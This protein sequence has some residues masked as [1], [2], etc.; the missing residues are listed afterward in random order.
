MTGVYLMS[1]FKTELVKLVI[2]EIRSII[3]I[4]LIQFVLGL[5]KTR[6]VRSYVGF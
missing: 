5:L 3:T 4:D 1:L 2:R 6:R